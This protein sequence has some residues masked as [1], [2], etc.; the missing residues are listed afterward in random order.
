MV[1]EVL[2][3]GIT[4][5]QIRSSIYTI[6]GVQVMLDRDIAKLYSV[7]TR[8]LNQAVSRNTERFPEEYCFQLSDAEFQ[9]W[10]SQLV[11]SKSNKMGLRRPPYAFSERGVAMLSTVLRSDSAIT[12]SMRIMDAFV[13]MRHYLVDN[14]LVFQR[15]DRIELKQLEVDEK[16]RQ[17]FRQLETPKP[18][19]AVIFFKGQMW[20]ATS[21]IEGIIERAERSIILI[22]GYVDK[23]TLDLLSKKKGEVSVSI[24]TTR[25]NCQ[26]TEKE[27]SDFNAQYGPLE[28][29]F[30]DEF[31]DRFV[32]LDEK[33][34]YHIGAS[35][36]DAG[37]K[38][39]EISLN[40]D[41]G[42]L[43]GLFLRL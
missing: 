10:K 34:L 43:K 23:R 41:D 24:H 28:I 20:D 16:F 2:E 36:K 9:E 35:I 30:T 42:I 22:D 5:E 15:L 39:F 38:A 21:C 17:L 27:I 7:E 3:L 6:R 19:K 14:A 8:V 29:R 12:I 32:I 37:R 25:K 31:H 18:N 1:K 13:A 33:E 26:L 40:E 11:M 4:A